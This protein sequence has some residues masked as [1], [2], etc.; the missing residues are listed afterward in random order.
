[1]QFFTAVSA[2]LMLFAAVFAYAIRTIPT[3][4]RLIN[5]RTELH[6]TAFES[7]RGLTVLN[8]GDGAVLVSAIDF[9]IDGYGMHSIA[10]DKTV[11]PGQVLRFDQPSPA[12]RAKRNMLVAHTSYSEWHTAMASARLASEWK[13]VFPIAFSESDSHYQMYAAASR[14][15]P[16]P[17]PSLAASA[18]LRY[19]DVRSGAGELAIPARAFLFRRSDCQPG[20]LVVPLAPNGAAGGAPTTRR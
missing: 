12:N 19:V 17:F 20:M 7:T 3:L 4:R 6:V 16:H 18:K 14:S 15:D 2:G 1:M 5:W 10:I 11:Q 9:S 13:C 8:S